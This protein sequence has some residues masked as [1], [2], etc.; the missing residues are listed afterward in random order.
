MK[1]SYKKLLAL[2]LCAAMLF[3]LLPAFAAA[4]DGKNDEPAVELPEIE[5]AEPAEEEQT[6]DPE[7]HVLDDEL[8]VGTNHAAVEPGETVYWRLVPTEDL[9]YEFEITGRGEICL[10]TDSAFQIMDSVETVSD[11]LSR[12]KLRRVLYAGETY[13]I[14]VRF[15][16][17][18]Q[19]GSISAYVRT[20][21]V[22]ACGNSMTWKFFPG[23]GVLSLGGTNKMWDFTPDTT[24]WAAYREQIRTVRMYNDGTS[25]P[26]SIGSYAFYGCSNLSSIENQSLMGDIASY[27]FSG[28]AIE[29]VACRG[30]VGAHA[31]EDCKN[32]QKV[33]LK[34]YVRSVG[35]YAFAGCENLTKVTTEQNIEWIG[36]HAF[37]N[38]GITE[39]TLPDIILAVSAYTFANCSDLTTV[40]LPASTEKIRENAFQ[41]CGLTALY[42]PAKVNEI[43]PTA[44]S[45]CTQLAADA[46]TVDPANETFCAEDG[47]LLSKDGKTLWLALHS[48]ASCT[49]PCCVRTVKTG[50]F[51]DSPTLRELIFSPGVKTVEAKAAENCA[52]LQTVTIPASLINIDEGAFLGCDGLTDVFYLGTETQRNEKLTVE[53]GNDALLSA[54]WHYQEPCTFDGT[55]EWNAG[56]VQF[57]GTTPYVVWNGGAF[58]P[59]FTLKTAEG[60]PVDPA[61]YSVEYRENVN[62]GT[63]YIFV[64][65]SEGYAGTMRLFFKIYLPATTE[66]DIWNIKDGIKLSW[67]PVEG[68]AGYVIYR[69]AWNL[70]SAGWTTFERWNNTTATTWTDTTVYAGTRYQYGVKAYFDKRTDAVTGAEIGGNVGDNYNLGIVGPLKTTVRI[71]SRHLNSL[72][73]GNKTITA[74]WEP[75]KV[76]TGY[77]LRYATDEAFTQNLKTVKV[78]GAEN[79]STVLKSL[80]N[81]T[82][83]YVCVRSYHVFEGMTYYGQWSNMIRVKPGSGQTMYDVMYRA[84]LI[85]EK[86]YSGDQK[87]KGPVNDMNAMA[88][89]L[90]GLNRPFAVKTLSNSKKAAILNAIKTTYADAMDNDVSL[91]YYSGHGVDAGGNDTYQG[92]LVPIDEN[93]ITMQE[94][95]A[96]L[97]KVRGRV[98]V[99]LDSCMSGAAIEPKSA[100]NAIGPDPMDEVSEAFFESAVEAFSGYY[101]DAEDG[102]PASNTRMG[103][104]RKSKF[105]VITAATAYRSSYEGKFDGTGYYQG[106]FTAALIKGLGCKYPKGNYSGSMPADTDSNNKVTL[107]EIY[108][109]AYDQAYSWT[110][111]YAKYYG[112][113][114]EVLFRR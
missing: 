64:T 8:I 65:F 108:R 76:F 16:N 63:A 96:E 20:Y 77:E 87:L 81:G 40:T 30:A 107:Y 59:G 73:A 67:K 24:P 29:A 103:E 88:G 83:Y 54:E 100:Q 97:S 28:T 113:N 101:L 6:E 39:I 95:A 17:P 1:T 15:S 90:K 37:E 72:K 91:F 60:E 78:A 53:D 7:H 58:T 80:T 19:G 114:N 105:I 66:M 51:T 41:N 25:N 68:A 27:A 26:R 57:R 5:D 82:Y 14:G 93:Y 104:F 70:Q 109:Y 23:D 10:L 12:E 110:G 85:G 74:T 92:A 47:M 44:F 49:V 84:L 111:Q 35:Q 69:R 36:A 61:T 89:M 102:E 32:L 21:K 4:E 112:P 9:T 62:A 42:V 43:D 106:A 45:G 86:D 98:V 71:T 48:L 18:G 33:F 13:Y 99:I 94:L 52:A 31:F 46:F 22:N 11:T 34:E 56:D 55:V 2:L 3:A 38:T 50:A 79:S 75:S